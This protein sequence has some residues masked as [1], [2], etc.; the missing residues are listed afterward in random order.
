[1]MEMES[2]LL[3]LLILEWGTVERDK[4]LLKIFK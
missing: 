2:A 1:M 3:V 4:N